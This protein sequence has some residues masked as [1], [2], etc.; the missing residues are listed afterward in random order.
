MSRLLLSFFCRLGR[1]ERGAAL[2]IFT[3]FLLPL[4]AVVAVSV[5]LSRVLLIKQKLTNAVDAAALAV[6]RHPALSDTDATAMADSFI[7]A[8]Y[9]ATDFGNLVS[10]AVVPS[11]SRVDVTATARIP[12][13]S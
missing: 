7:H 8:H 4:L 13:P 6:G 1:D 12:R 11:T 10:F 3:L 9:T 2:L 5:D